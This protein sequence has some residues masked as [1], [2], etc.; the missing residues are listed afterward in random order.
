MNIGEASKASKVSAKMIRYYEQIGLILRLTAPIRATAPIPRT[1]FTG[2][3]SSGVR[4][5]SASRW[6]RSR[7]C[8]DCGMTSRAR[9]LM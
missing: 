7:T 2:C 8:W 1:T 9:V 4:A 3:I 6:P 5:T